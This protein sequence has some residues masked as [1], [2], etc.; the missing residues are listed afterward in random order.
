MAEIIS[1]IIII[2][3]IIIIMIMIIIMMRNWG[4]EE[5]EDDIHTILC[6]TQE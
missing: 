4:K 2:I 3:I 6:P 5:V 1:I